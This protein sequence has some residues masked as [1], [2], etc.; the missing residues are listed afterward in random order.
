[1]LIYGEPWIGSNDPDYEANPSW[2]WYKA[3]SPITFFQDD[4]RNAFK[5]TTA[6][7][8]LGPA[9]R[10]YAGGDVSAR[11]AALQAVANDYPE[12]PTARAGINYLDIH[13]NWALADRFATCET[14]DCAWD[15]RQGVREAE[16]RIG[17]AL[18]MTSL[19]PVVIH[20]GTEIARSKGL[21]PLPEEIGGQLVLTDMEMAPIYIKGRGDTYNLR[22]ANAFVWE[23]VGQTAPVDAASMADWWRGLTALRL[24]ETGEVFRVGEAVPDGWVRPVL[25]DDRPDVLGYTV[26]DRVLTMVNVGDDVATLNLEHRRRLAAGGGLGRVGRTRGPGRHRGGRAARHLARPGQGRPHLGARLAGRDVTG[27]P[28]G[29]H[30]GWPARVA[31]GHDARRSRVVS[32]QTGGRLRRPPVAGGVTFSRAP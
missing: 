24:S 4:A 30:V 3:D 1:M 12:E 10:G 32:V 27:C 15:G 26:G 23:T 11:D 14:G 7:P 19:G 28:E 25:L 17:A 20:G 2:D 6:D 5:G 31:S 29:L 22:A 13:D 18:L 8:T 16:M 9:S 21:A